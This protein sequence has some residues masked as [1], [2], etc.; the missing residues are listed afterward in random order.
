MLGD[1]VA[2]RMVVYGGNE[3]YTRDGVEVVGLPG[4]P[5]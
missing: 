5:S 3:H 4:I 1:A 2:R